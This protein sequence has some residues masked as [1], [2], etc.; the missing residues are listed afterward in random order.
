MLSANA[1]TRSEVIPGLREA[2]L[3]QDFLVRKRGTLMAMVSPLFHPL[4]KG[5]RGGTYQV[6]RGG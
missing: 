2:T 4:Q 5:G 1:A 6:S 3:G